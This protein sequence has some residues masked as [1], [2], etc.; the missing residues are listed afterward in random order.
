MV[1]IHVS[2]MAQSSA[3]NKSCSPSSKT[4][5]PGDNL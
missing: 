4:D 5:Y 1:S 2:H 3:L